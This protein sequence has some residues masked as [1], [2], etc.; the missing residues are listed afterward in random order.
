[1][2]KTD[3]VQNKKEDFKVRLRS[4]FGVSGSGLCVPCYA[5]RVP[6]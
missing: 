2:N 1:M 5:F 4:G 6:C 3:I